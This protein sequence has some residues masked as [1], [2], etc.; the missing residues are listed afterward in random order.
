[1]V[2]VKDLKDLHGS[3][4]ELV[5]YKSFYL[6]SNHSYGWVSVLLKKKKSAQFENETKQK[7]SLFKT[8]TWDWDL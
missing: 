5:N 6:L 4:T 8:K 3:R 7:N 1:M 2:A